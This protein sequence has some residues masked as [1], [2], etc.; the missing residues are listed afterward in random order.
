M[1]YLDAFWSSDPANPKI[2][3]PFEL[4]LGGCRDIYIIS[5]NIAANVHITDPT[6]GSGA[7]LLKT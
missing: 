3:H 5:N 1:I 7:D 4:T 6:S 2:T